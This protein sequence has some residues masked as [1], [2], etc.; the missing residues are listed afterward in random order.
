MKNRCIFEQRALFVI[1]TQAKL[2]SSP[3]Q[4]TFAINASFGR[5]AATFN[6]LCGFSEQML[7]FCD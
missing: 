4:A 3:A 7:S 1:A 6:K 2:L 5:E